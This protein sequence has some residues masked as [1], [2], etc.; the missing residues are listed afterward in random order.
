MT[1][2]AYFNPTYVGFLFICTFSVKIALS[3]LPL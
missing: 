3:L 1:S 2:I